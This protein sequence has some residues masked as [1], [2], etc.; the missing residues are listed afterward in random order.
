MINDTEIRGLS[1]SSL[2]SPS[3][4][5]G[6]EKS[7][8][9]TE[10]NGPRTRS[11]NTPSPPSYNAKLAT[12]YHV[13]GSSAPLTTSSVNTPYPPSDNAKVA[14]EQEAPKKIMC[15]KDIL[16]GKVNEVSAIF[17][18]MLSRLEDEPRS[19]A[20]GNSSTSKNAAANL[21]QTTEGSSS[22]T[23]QFR[24]CTS[25]AKS[26]NAVAMQCT[27][28]ANT[29][30][31]VANLKQTKKDCSSS[32]LPVGEKCTADVSGK[33]SEGRSKTLFWK[34]SNLVL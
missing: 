15:R 22:S 11:V 4:P 12:D 3:P 17:R 31:A 21:K 10:S 6:T 29:K 27:S 18:S 32:T 33:R 2:N 9:D 20:Q 13:K 16:N 24:E 14:S 5:S 25:D 34:V 8:A 1:P 7:T 23:L 28:D 26:K 19:N 30:N